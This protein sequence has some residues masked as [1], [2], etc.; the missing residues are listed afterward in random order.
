[1]EKARVLLYKY[2]FISDNV[3]LRL[4]Y[5]EFQIRKYCIV[6]WYDEKTCLIFDIDENFSAG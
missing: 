6:I 1:M 5:T 4:A 2:M 3:K